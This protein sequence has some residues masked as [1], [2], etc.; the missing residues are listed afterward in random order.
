MGAFAFSQEMGDITR[1]G[2]VQN[3]DY[4]ET[5]ALE[6]Y[7][8]RYSILDSWINITLAVLA[9]HNRSINKFVS[10]FLACHAGK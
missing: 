3:S 6:C 2:R 9:K 5:R 10:I 4:V 7:C 8:P 1:V